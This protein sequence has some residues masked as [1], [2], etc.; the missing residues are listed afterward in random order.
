[1]LYGTAQIADRRPQAARPVQYAT[2]GPGHV[3]HALLPG[4]TLPKHLCVC[5][6]FWKGGGVGQTLKT[7]SP[8]FICIT[9]AQQ[10]LQVTPGHEWAHLDG[11]C[12]HR[13]CWCEP[14]LCS[15]R[16]AATTSKC[17]HLSGA[18][19]LPA[20][21]VQGGHALRCAHGRAYV[22]PVLAHT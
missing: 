3:H 2:S 8:A 16:H 17:G 9:T 12:S 1:M 4:G 21:A 14:S 7:P 5:V 11:W 15:H 6:C 13:Y 20:A 19:R 18:C 10:L 22:R